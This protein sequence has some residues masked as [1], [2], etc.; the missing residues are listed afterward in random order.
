MA[1]FRWKSKADRNM[2]IFRASIQ[3][4]RGFEETAQMINELVED[5]FDEYKGVSPSGNLDAPFDDLIQNYAVNLDNM[6]IRAIRMAKKAI[7][8]GV[9]ENARIYKNEKALEWANKEMR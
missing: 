6:P 7:L 4:Y 8:V 2:F 3:V 5:G 1:K 9:Y